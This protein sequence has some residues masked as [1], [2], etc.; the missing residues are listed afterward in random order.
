MNLKSIIR[1]SAGFTLDALKSAPVGSVCSGGNYKFTKID[2]NVWNNPDGNKTDSAVFDFLKG[3]NDSRCSTSIADY[4]QLKKGV[5]GYDALLRDGVVKIPYGGVKDSARRKRVRDARA[6]K[7]HII[8]DEA[9]RSELEKG[10]TLS[11]LEEYCVT[12]DSAIR[13]NLKQYGVS[14]SQD[15]EDVDYYTV[16]LILDV[17]SSL[18]RDADLGVVTQYLADMFLQDDED[19]L[20]DSIDD[21]SIVDLLWVLRSSGVAYESL[22]SMGSDEKDYREYIMGLIEENGLL[23]LVSENP[24]SDA[25]PGV[26]WSNELIED[27]ESE[28][29]F[30]VLSHDDFSIDVIDRNGSGGD[31]DRFRV[32]TSGKSYADVVRA[33]IGRPLKDSVSAQTSWQDVAEFD[34]NESIEQDWSASDYWAYCQDVVQGFTTPNWFFKAPGA[35][36]GSGNVDVF[37]KFVQDFLAFNEESLRQLSEDEGYPDMEL[38]QAFLIVYSDKIVDSARTNNKI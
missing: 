10:W 38:W 28:T 23:P 24:L 3:F 17:D 20:D 21:N 2:K 27:L 14:T 9:F 18:M 36:D 22:K 34:F 19:F 29:D 37:S 1:D 31:S 25:A 33:V 35:T 16:A 32:E 12:N 8:K 13:M 7:R 30:D 5:V 11:D 4:V 15:L 6:R 26:A